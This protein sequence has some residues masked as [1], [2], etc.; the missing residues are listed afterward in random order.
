[1]DLDSYAQDDGEGE[2]SLDRKL[3][4]IPTFLMMLS[5]HLNYKLYL[6]VKKV[7]FT[8]L[9]LSLDICE[10]FSEDEIMLMEL[11]CANRDYCESQTKVKRTIS[12]GIRGFDDVNEWWQS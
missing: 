8:A 9:R 5:T 4:T 1:M 12:N 3:T 2:T 7:D 10:A 6:L 11:V